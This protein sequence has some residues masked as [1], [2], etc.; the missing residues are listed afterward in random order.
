MSKRFFSAPLH[1]GMARP[2]DEDREHE[3]RLA[4]RRAA[5]IPICIPAAADADAPVGT[6]LEHKVRRAVGTARLCRLRAAILCW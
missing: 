2:W 5:V 3:T 1:S 6:L 4:A